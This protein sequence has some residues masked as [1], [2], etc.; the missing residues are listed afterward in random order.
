MTADTIEMITRETLLDRVRAFRDLRYRLVQISAARLPD[1]MEITYS[2]DLAGH[3]ISLRI[4][5]PPE[6]LN[7]PS[8]SSIYACVLLYEN[9]MHDLFGIHVHDMAVDFKGN[10]YKTSVKYPL[11]STKVVCGKPDAPVKFQ[12]PVQP[13]STAP[14]N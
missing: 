14:T 8:I 9:E 13:P 5:L 6:D 4:L 12:A 3:M 1:S 2:F 11:G 10:L 7:I